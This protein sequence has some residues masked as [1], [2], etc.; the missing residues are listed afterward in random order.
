[1]S[2]ISSISN[3]RMLSSSNAA[4]NELVKKYCQRINE[5]LGLLKL[6]LD[7]VLPQ[8]TL[9]DRLSLVLEELDAGINDAIKLVG[10]WDLMTS[11]IYFVTQAESLV[12]K[13]QNCAF[14]A[15]QVV[16]TLKLPTEA[17]CVSVYLEKLKKC[18]C[19]NITPVIGEA[20]ADIVGKVMPK[21]ENLT[22]IQLCLSLSTN[23]ELL[24]EAVA[25]AKIKRRFNAEDSA[26]MDAI[27]DISE[28]VNY[29][30]EKHVEEKQM[31][32][33]N[34]V[35]IPAD[36]C[37]PLSLELMSDPVIVASGQTYERV[38]IRKW[39]DLGYKVCPKT[40]QTLGH[41]NLIP[42]YTVKQLI[43][44]WSEIHGIMLPDPVKLLSMSFPVSLNLMSGKTSDE[45]PSSDNS[46]RTYKSGPPEDISVDDSHYHDSMHENSDSDDQIS[47]ASTFDD[48][49]DSEAGS[50]KLPIAATEA[51]KSTCIETIDDPE[52]LKQ[53]RKDDFQAYDVE[54]HL[55]SNGSS[56]IG[57]GA[58]SSS[59]HLK[60][61][62]KN[63]EEQ[64]LTN[65]MASEATRNG[66]VH[67][68]SKVEP[69]VLPRFG[70]FRSQSQLTWRR[71]SDK[72]VLMDPRPDFLSVDAEVCKLIEDLRNESTD[73]QRAAI[74][75][76]RVLS[77]HNMEN[78]IA[79]AKHGAIPFLASL[80]YSTDPTIQEN[81]VTVLLNLSLS[82][83]NKIAIVNAD[84]IEPLIHALE[85]G[86]PEAKANSAAT[87]FSLSAIGDN[88]AKIGRSGAIK[89]LVNLLQDGSAQGKKDAA[90]ALYNL[91]LFQENKA[92]IVEAGAV[93]H[94]VELMD[95]AAGMVDKAVAVLAI[96]ATV[97]EGRNGIAQ[98]GGIPMLVEVV[99]LGSARAKENAAAAL[100][101]LCT[102]NSRFCS[103]VLQEGAM[104]PLVALSQSGTARAREKAQVLL[105]YFRNQ[106]QVGKVIRR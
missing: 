7:E 61:V 70:C 103:L 20:S 92:R 13:M 100:L 91:S 98:A 12:T 17:N 67:T 1:M 2:I 23:Q 68:C 73:I 41:T 84:A 85:T 16:S 31:H 24:M 29:M 78:R 34:G 8:I 104:P 58:S 75:E 106:R 5:L 102:N 42:N 90:T 99:E 83:D 64:A 59:N 10:S 52:A 46:P 28:L 94:L 4:E 87:L 43:E 60:V 97:Q 55:P 66:P 69:N 51:N 79:I 93:K 22:N 57:T 86:N 63:K 39:L 35:P 72:A 71:Q 26:E 101:Q 3:F 74:G 19:D 36:F 80:L 47:K 38:F 33:I 40:L 54:R 95:P 105:S 37:C 96:L 77:R 15:C 6:V 48:T 82:D 76:L 44:N 9:D 88:K 30:L 53:L 25:L 32:S 45:S 56:D 21:S 27:N 49:D 89:L 11:K 62:G 50:S 18:Q 14:E 81:A 65:S